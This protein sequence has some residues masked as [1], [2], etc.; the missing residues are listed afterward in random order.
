MAS[1][2]LPALSVRSNEQSPLDTYA[3]MLSIRQLMGQQ[4]LQ[5]GQIQGQQQQLQSGSIDLQLK[6]QA[7]KNAT[8]TNSFLSDPHAMD[9]YK[10]WQSTKGSASGAQAAP[11]TGTQSPVPLHPLAQYLAEK[12]NLPLYGPGGALEISDTLTKSAQAIATLTKTQ[13]EVAGQNLT[14]HSKQLEN[15][16]Q[17]AEPVLSETDAAKQTQG[18][19]NLRSEIQQHPELYP[20]EATQHLDKLNSVQTLQQAFNTSQ[21]RQM[22]IEEG[23]KQAGLTK[24]QQEADPVLK[25]ATPEALA[26][27]GA[28]AAIQA[29]LNDPQTKEQD[30]PRLQALL[31]KA[32]AAAAQV[33]NMKKREDLAQQQVSQGDP[34]AAG[35]LLASR[36]LT[37]DELK[38]RQAT[39]DFIEKAVM[40]AQKY[41]PSFKAPEAAA[42]GAI[43]K[44][45]QNQ[46]FFGNTDSL[47]IKGGTLD[48]LSQA[49]KNLGDTRLPAWNSVENMVKASLG[50]GPVAA[51]AAAVLNV[52]DDQAKVMG[53]TGA[54]TDTSRKQS[55]DL[56][57]RNM[58]PEAREAAINQVRQGVLSQ[59][60]GRQGS[61]PYL[62]DMYPEPD[63]AER[64][65]AVQHVPGGQAAGL[66]EGQ[67]GTGS[68]NKKYVVR[69]GV[70]QA[71]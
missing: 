8:V 40:S 50:K 49:G 69:N 42:Q 70:W 35:K 48:Q 33:V 18:L 64:G 53:G 67:T 11:S 6:Q 1:I 23:T 61:N 14:N 20:P 9:D 52:A 62:K 39:P 16:D 27:P 47:L 29:K 36:A 13:G 2:P 68:D 25:L 56:Y 45:P 22:V 58:S 19:S 57:G 60:R 41:D 21:L 54:A 26:A 43:A 7:L 15:F 28:K 5:Q 59:R 44:A 71:Q 3:K 51:Y 55:L 66:K 34:D 46:M 30:I 37:L 4:Q 32:D 10:E 12:K 63:G 17:L 31:P 38:L 24:A 65:A